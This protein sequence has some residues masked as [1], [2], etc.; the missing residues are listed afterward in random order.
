MGLVDGC[1]P[2]LLSQVSN[3]DHGGTGIVYTLNTMAVQSGFIFGP[4][5]GSMIM[6][7]SSFQT[8][9][10][11]L[12]GFMIVMAPVMMV[13]KGLETPKEAVERVK[14]ENE[15]L[16]KAESVDVGGNEL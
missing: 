7:Y 16:V 12:G 4:I 11:V 1:S 14:K 5:C 9:S 3:K 13:N 8:M 2:A 15:S 6:Q 10:M